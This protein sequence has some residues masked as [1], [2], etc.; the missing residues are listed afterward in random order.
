M[1]GGGARTANSDTIGV[2]PR[3]WFAF[4]ALLVVGCTLDRVTLSPGAAPRDAGL[5]AALA[6]SDGG[7]PDARAL[8]D[9]RIDAWQ[10]QGLPD[11]AACPLEPCGAP[12][13]S[14]PHDGIPTLVP[15]ERLEINLCG[16]ADDHE[17]SDATCGRA[18]HGEDSLVRVQIEARGRYRLTLR[19]VDGP[20]AIDTV[21]YLR[22]D[23]EVGESEFACDDDVDCDDA[24]EDLRANC[25]GGRQ[26]RQSRLD[27][28]LERGSYFAV[29]DSVE[30]DGFRC[31][32][33]QLRLRAR[34]DDSDD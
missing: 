25:E 23:C 5:D 7:E 3:L 31:G 20:V 19:D 32:L 28:R 2:P 17:Q 30:R 18:A 6:V 11:A 26:P 21:L 15:G 16:T 27:V 1:M 9:A 8:A 13:G 12:P 33:V 10:G 24:D 34:G 22:S 14:C 29:I 4:T